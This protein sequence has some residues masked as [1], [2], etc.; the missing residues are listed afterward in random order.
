VPRRIGDLSKEKVCKVAN[1]ALK[2]EAK[3][4]ARGEQIF[5]T[6]RGL[7]EDEARIYVGC[8]RTNHI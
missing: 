1:L 6:I 7:Q 3:K 4:V 8:R 2:R 5:Q